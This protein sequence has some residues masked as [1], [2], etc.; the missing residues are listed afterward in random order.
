[1]SKHTDGPWTASEGFPS[2]VWHIDMPGRSFSVVVSRTDSDYDMP[3]SE[4]QANARLIAAAPELLAALEDVVASA[5]ANC[6]GS[7]ANAIN[8]GQEAIDKAKEE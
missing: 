2:D 7:L 6:S 8:A 4:V 5:E 1:M 3:V